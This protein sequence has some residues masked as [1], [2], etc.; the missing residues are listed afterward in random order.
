MKQTGN[1]RGARV[2]DILAIRNKLIHSPEV[3]EQIPFYYRQLFRRKQYYLNELWVNR[4]RELSQARAAYDNYQKGFRGGLL[5]RGERNSGR[6]FFSQYAARYLAPEA[7]IYTV[8]PP[9]SGSL[10]T[11]IFKTQLQ[12]A[13]DIYGSYD[14]IFSKMDSQAILVI[15][16][17]ELW[18]EKSEN[19]F[20]VIDQIVFLMERYSPKCWFIVNV[21]THSFR[22]INSIKKIESYF[23]KLVE[24]QPFNAEQLRDIILKRH[25]SSS[26]RYTFKNRKSK[27][28]TALDNARLFNRYFHYSQGNVGV[29]LNA[30][31]TNITSVE[32][33][34]LRIKFPEVPD[35]RVLD[36]LESDWLLI[37]LQFV[38]HKRLTL[39]RLQ[40]ITHENANVLLKKLSTLKR[41]GI[42]TESNGVYEPDL[43]LYP[44][45]KNR[46]IE[47]QVL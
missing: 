20:R 15:D 23:L 39:Q 2:D 22:V 31:L 5:V 21:N 45:I 7:R 11:S 9:F 35:A 16:D 33:N 37:I 47:K 28:I 8:Y 46:L 14:E 30:W 41:A 25:N 32:N 12:K 36:Y 43:N 40:R 3:E 27:Y 38:L 10:S 19:G 4:A 44:F 18:W 29:A 1:E 6:S 26:L 17:L 42:I 34:T 24:L 13:T